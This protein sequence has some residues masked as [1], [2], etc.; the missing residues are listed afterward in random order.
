MTGMLG[1]AVAGSPTEPPGAA[2]PG[3]RRLVVGIGRVP[4]GPREW[5]AYM[6]A[7]ARLEADLGQPVVVRLLQD[8]DAVDQALRF[9]EVDIA[10]VSVS[11]YLT[12]ENEARTVLVAAP[13]IDSRVRNSA[14]LVVRADSPYQELEDLRGARVALRPGSLGGEGFAAWFLESQGETIDSFF[15]SVVD[16]ESQDASLRHVVQGSA[17]ATFVPRWDL[18]GWSDETFRSLAES[19]EWAMP[20]IVAQSDLGVD[21]IDSI[22]ESLT[23]ESTAEALMESR[24]LDGFYAV[25]PDD[26]AFARTLMSYATS[27]EYAGEGSSE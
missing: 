16:T 27:G 5:G 7:F 8:Y 10:L 6:T 19:P 14:M 25:A 17:D 18:F 1:R 15:S 4:G 2:E 26:Y 13:T 11:R 12:A 23:S 22:R 20:P 3:A 9:E 21:L 24:A